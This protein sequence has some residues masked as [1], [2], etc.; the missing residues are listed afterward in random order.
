[1]KDDQGRPFCCKVY[2][3]VIKLEGDVEIAW[4]IYHRLLALASISMF[5]GFDVN[6]N[7]VEGFEE[8]KQVVDREFFWRIMAVIHSKTVDICTERMKHR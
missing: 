8:Y 7:L 3:P 2:G 1:M 6:M 4:I 5:G